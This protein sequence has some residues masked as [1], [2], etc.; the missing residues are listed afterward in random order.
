MCPPN[1]SKTTRMILESL[2]YKDSKFKIKY[3]KDPKLAEK[4]RIKNKKT[5]SPP[6][7]SL[8]HKLFSLACYE[9]IT[10][11]FIA[12]SRRIALCDNVLE[13]LSHHSRRPVSVWESVPWQGFHKQ[14]SLTWMLW[15]QAWN[16]S[17]IA[18]ALLP[19]LWHSYKRI[20]SPF[21]L[22]SWDN[23]REASRFPA[24]HRR[25]HKHLQMG[26]QSK[27]FLLQM[28]AFESACDLCKLT[29]CTVEELSRGH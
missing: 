20:Q 28:T 5:T 18:A 17:C 16:R 10:N 13:R 8:Q 25:L 12:Y 26:I 3:A 27:T 19:S 1:M 21:H 9:S 14:G 15:G 23:G 11:P 29:A 22:W 7:P 2:V 6:A 24:K 4:E